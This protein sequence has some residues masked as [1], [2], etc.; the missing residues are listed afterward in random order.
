[1]PAGGYKSAMHAHTWFVF[2]AA[3]V[4]ICLAP[5]PDMLFVVA[6]AARGGARSGLDAVRG[7]T[8]AMAL[9]VAAASLGL[10]A[11]FAAS[12]G[13][14]NVLRVVGAIY[15]VWLGINAL[16]GGGASRASAVPSGEAFRRGFLTNVS[17]PKVIVFFAAFLPQFVVPGAGPVAMQ[18]L[19]LGAVFAGVGL[20][21]DIS[22]AFAAGA[23]GAKF[24][25]N[26]RA[27]RV[28][29]AVAGIVMIVLGIEL[30]SEPR[31]A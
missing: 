20:A 17:N 21:F 19:E 6:S 27:I 28:L 29:D 16:R 26:V 12:A 31:T 1:M 9:H 22:I 13:A 18:L 4:A 23:L 2:L 3:T 14:F 25:D 15:L 8:T 10:S 5:G 30:F 7:I 11:L 24:A